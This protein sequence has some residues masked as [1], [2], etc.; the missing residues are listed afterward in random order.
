MILDGALATHRGERTALQGE[1]LVE[2]GN[3]GVSDSF[4]A[5]SPEDHLVRLAV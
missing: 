4:H 3:P 2:G 5:A 1:S